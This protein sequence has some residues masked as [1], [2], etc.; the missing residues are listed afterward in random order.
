MSIETGHISLKLGKTLTK[1]LLKRYEEA[2]KS[3]PGV[4]FSFF[5]KSLIWRTIKK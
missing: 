5:I 2:K 4:S 1:E 3:T